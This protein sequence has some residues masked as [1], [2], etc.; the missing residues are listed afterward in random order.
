MFIIPT[1][2]ILSMLVFGITRI[3]PGDLIDM[4]VSEQA[5]Y[6]EI[7]RA[8]VEKSLGLDVPI[9]VQYTRW[10]SQII[11]KGD[12]G[13]SLW[14]GTSVTD[15]IIKRLPVTFELGVMAIII[16]LVIAFPVGILSA[17][18]QDT[19]ADYIGRTVAVT[20]LSVPNFWIGTMVMVFPAIWWGWSP[21]VIYIPFKED[22]LGNLLQFIIPAVIMGTSMAAIIM[23]MT[24]TMMLEVL[25][26][27]YIRTAWAKGLRERV[28]VVRHA[29]KNAMIPIITIIGL[30]IP[31]VVGGS[32]IMEQIFALPGMGR[33]VV[34]ATFDRDYPVI[35]AVALFISVAILLVNL[36]I[37]LSYAYLDPR[38]RYE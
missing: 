2:I 34:S 4:M 10:V 8:Q 5:S 24:R 25:R 12:F 16:A 26:Q 27:D 11:T 17:L 19:V 29:L 14:R 18:R 37:D 30:I 1:L 15:D 3:I 9:Y 23:R 31:T 32:V 20:G 7:D 6:T 33:L 22:P 28:V 38:I 21:P 13:K 36:L 35:I